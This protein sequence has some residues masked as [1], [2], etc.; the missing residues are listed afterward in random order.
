MS[1]RSIPKPDKVDVV[2]PIGCSPDWGHYEE[3]RYSLRSLQQNL[4][5]LGTVYLVG[6]LPD[7]ATNVM[8]IPHIDSYGTNKDANLI[9]KVLLACYQPE[10]T[11]HFIRLSDDQYMLR[12][13]DWEVQHRAVSCYNIL[14]KPH[15]P[16]HLHKDRRHRTARMLQA[17]GCAT[18]YFDGH[19]PYVYDKEQFPAAMLN[20]NYGADNG[21]TINSLYFN[22]IGTPPYPKLNEALLQVTKAMSAEE[23]HK[24][25][26]GKWY[27][28]NTPKGLNSGLKR[29]LQERFP[30]KSRFEK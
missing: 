15:E 12:P 26:K 22:A 19:M 17:W 18:W 14:E 29:F 6:Q 4:D 7:W 20:F 21:Y 27:M 28:F 24:Q 1:I 2:Y 3:L 5:N 30:N 23:L 9:N 11:R 25:A 8:H 10:L 16:N 13:Y